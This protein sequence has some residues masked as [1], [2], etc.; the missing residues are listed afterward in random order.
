MKR[1]G[2]RSAIAV[3]AVLCS[4]SLSG[5]LS[6]AAF[7]QVAGSG[8]ISGAITDPTGAVIPGA[9]V[10]LIHSS[11]GVTQ[12]V[13]A[14]AA[15]L[16]NFLSLTPGTYSLQVTHGGF[17]TA[18]HSEIRVTVDQTTTVDFKLQVGRVTQV[19]RISGSSS[20]AAT[21]NT[22]VGALISRK[23]IERVPLLDR[24]VYS[25][26]QL[27]P[28]VIPSD[29]TPNSSHAQY[30][31]SIT[32]G[33]PGINVSSYGFNG[34][35][36]GSVYYM[37]DGSP[38]GVAENNVGAILPAFS[39]PESAIQEVRVETQNT[40]A[41]YDSGGAGVISLATK[42]GG[43]HF[44]GELFGVFRPDIFAA[45]DY[46]NKQSQILAGT[47]NTPPSF[48]RYQEGGSLG[49]PI[50]VKR[51]FFFGDFESTQ[52]ALFDGSNV[53][54]V[55]TKDERTG[56][57]SHDS[58]TIYDPL[59][60]DDSNGNRQP[61]PGNVIPNPNPIALKALSEMPEC[62]FPNPSTCNQIDTNSGLPNFYMPGVDPSKNQALDFRLDLDKSQKQ[63]IFGRYTFVHSTHALVNAYGNMWDPYYAQNV[64]NAWNL[65]LADNYTFNS[66]TM[67]QVRA[68]F[69]RHRENQGGDPAQNGYDLTQLGFPSA[70]AA[71][72]VYKILPRFEFEDVGGGVGGTCC[73]NTFQYASE[74]ADVNFTFTRV[75]GKNLISAGFE[76]MK[77]YLNV[78]QPYSPSGAYYFSQSAT[79]QNTANGGGG[80]DFASFLIGMGQQPGSE[81]DNWTK[82]LFVAEASPYYGSFLQDTYHAMRNLTIT[83]GLRWD[84]FSP[85]TERHNRMEYFNPTAG[86]TSSG[87]S[88][89]GAEIFLNGNHRRPFTTN[90]GDLS[91]RLGFTWQ[92]ITRLVVNGGTGIYYGPSAEA[93]SS[94]FTNSDGYSSFT[95]WNST[96]YNADGNT[97]FFGSSACQGAQAG[98]PAPSF[99]GPYSLSDPFPNGV[100]PTF[101][102]PPTGLATGLG[103]TL[104]TVLHTE[105]TPTIYNINFGVSYKMLADYILSLAYVGSVGRY[106][107]KASFDANQLSIQT[108]QK[109]GA[110]LCVF[111][112][113]AC[114]MVPNTWEAIQPATNANYGSSTVPL[115]V[116]VQDFPQFGNGSYGNG[117]GVLING[118]PIGDSSYNSLQV[119][120]QKRLSRNFTTIDSFTWGKLMTDDPNPP[121]NFVGSHDGSSQDPK[122]P[123]YDHALSPQ[124][125]KYNFVGMV[126]YSLPI[127][128][129]QAIHF[130]KIGN[131]LLG[132]WTL[133]GIV[134][135][136]SGLPIPGPSAGL[137]E[138]YFNQRSNM[139]CNP[140][141]NAPRTVNHWFNYSCF[142]IPSSPFVP[143]TTPDFMG[144]IRTMG[145]RDL[146]MSVY[147]TFP[148]G[149]ERS[150]RFEAESYNVT[151]TVQ[152]GMP[153]V[154]SIHGVEKHPS[155]ALSFGQITSDRNSPRQFQFGARFRF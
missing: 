115:W 23:T 65:L 107:P 141:K 155:E 109:Y 38:I 63:H 19:V 61:F 97:T 91:P 123:Q 36:L 145:A 47:S 121:L 24:D 126:S 60:P 54:T 143:G 67:L 125:V 35:I 37:L 49:G 96:C 144:A 102:K 76:F 52:Q 69:T 129:G 149:D 39:P 116:A 27:S 113:S 93:V 130:N 124:D 150:L 136:S 139:N 99:S 5:L 71:Q 3:G 51:L 44:H 64:T 68:S 28:G 45:N 20:L 75:Q 26:V 138:E 8:A 15:G 78:G 6:S 104:N 153:T 14:N 119:K 135:L 13:T 48:H 120:V 108:I 53:F 114:K 29:A 111:P 103:T 90:F 62:N 10:T 25:L 86:G 57:F 88:F 42:S 154:N 118:D 18:V 17:Q 151:N 33:R 133:N 122:D 59:L 66:N 112:T 73:E 84:V 137:P 147:K 132:G 30:I 4:L 89:T 41:S 152:F 21:T 87:V 100:V 134:Y 117:N 140:G 55:P 46:F 70:L 2:V 9:K 11:T 77:R 72:E 85:R 56:N 58:F 1:F 81:A 105:R 22:T 131:A 34:D 80:S 7:A 94:A 146:D 92:P 142:S 43:A 101:T 12:S 148:L 106:L 40:P 110:S 128:K 31:S 98:S 16:F 74:N 95:N 50:L 82:D 32:N 127:G 79:D 83:A